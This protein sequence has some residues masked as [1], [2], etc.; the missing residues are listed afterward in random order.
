MAAALVTGPDGFF[1]LG[2]ANCVVIVVG[3]F[4]PIAKPVALALV[5]R[6]DED[7][8]F[9]ALVKHV[10]MAMVIGPEDRLFLA[11]AKHV[12]TWPE[13]DWFFVAPAKR[14]PIAVATEPDKDWLFLA[15]AKLV[16]M[17]TVTRCDTYGFICGFLRVATWVA[18][19]SQRPSETSLGSSVA[20]FCVTMSW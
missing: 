10:A 7:W 4:L 20:T 14:L 8:L 18:T 12:V 13:E 15:T 16:V 17:A 1:F 19:F 9:L 11:R 2:L 6:P 3:L 5:I